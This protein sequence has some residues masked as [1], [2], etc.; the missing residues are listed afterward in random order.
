MRRNNVLLAVVF[1]F[2]IGIIVVIAVKY[3]PFEIIFD[4]SDNDFHNGE[5]PQEFYEHFPKY[6]FVIKDILYGYNTK[7]KAQIISVDKEQITYQVKEALVKVGTIVSQGDILCNETNVTSE[8]NGQVSYISQDDENYLISI[9]NFENIEL[10]TYLDVNHH[11][12]DDETKI[13]AIIKDHKIKLTLNYI[14]YLNDWPR[15]ENACIGLK[16][17]DFSKLTMPIMA[18]K[19]VKIFFELGIL[20]NQ[21]SLPTTIRLYNDRLLLIIRDDKVFHTRLKLGVTG[22]YYY[23]IL[24]DDIQQGDILVYE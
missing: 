22:L 8:I 19:E 13:Y 23:Q 11:V 21:L 3:I 20:S 9:Y 16:I 18:G 6:P 15:D 10:V 5:T 2:L 4:G 1:C 14:Y 12:I 7:A 24:N 17:D